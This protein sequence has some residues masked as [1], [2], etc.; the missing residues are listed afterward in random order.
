MLKHFEI[1][2]ERINQFTN[3][4]RDKLYAEKA[5][6]ALS[7]YGPTDRITLDEALSQAKFKPA[8]IGEKFGP[9]WSTHWFKVEIDV[10]KAWRGK[11]AHLLWDSISEGLIYLDGKPVQALTGTDWS[12]RP[13]R[14]EWRLPK[15]TTQLTVYIE[16]AVNHLFGFNEMGN[17][18][19]TYFIG[20][21]R[22]AEIGLFDRDAWNLLW[23]YSVVAESASEMPQD[24]VRGRQAMFAANAFINAIRL[25]DKRTWPG[26]RKIL[27]QFLAARNGDS[28]HNVSAIGHA[29]IDTAWLW[30]LAETRRKVIRTVSTTMRLMEDYPEYK[31]S[32]SQA[33]Q[34]DW[35]KE[36][37]P[38]LY[39]QLKKRVKEGRVVPVGGMWVEPDTN[40]PS[41]ES[42]I[43]QML[44]GQRWF[45]R[46]YGLRCNEIWIPDVFGYCAPTAANSRTGRGHAF[47]YAEALVEPDEQAAAPH[48]LLGGVGRHAHADPL[49]AHR[50][51]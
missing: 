25:D 26:A 42:L 37:R 6:V 11:E 28:Q 43:R 35:V 39:A 40:V 41:G 14:P 2:R 17:V 38:D 5:P 18:Q 50:H 22:Q 48:L 47:S 46:E 44:I 29:H 3:A 16:M 45:E 24:S 1:T 4:L 51:V 33:V 10:P 49:P 13:L 15:R 20:M 34:H 19:E 23:D 36:M 12:G 8:K 7:V 21:L 9:P 27:S 32:F 31:F 30:P